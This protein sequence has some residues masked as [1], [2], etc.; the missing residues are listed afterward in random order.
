MESFLWDDNVFKLKKKTKKKTRGLLFLWC[1]RV[2]FVQPL[3][4][5]A[6]IKLLGKCRC[7]RFDSSLRLGCIVWCTLSLQKLPLCPLDPA[8]TSS[9][10]RVTPL[11]YSLVQWNWFSMVTGCTWVTCIQW[12][13]RANFTG[14]L[15]LKMQKIH[16]VNLIRLTSEITRNNL[17][18]LNLS[19][20]KPVRSLQKKNVGT[21]LRTTFARGSASR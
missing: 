3:S 19:P 10:S 13:Q 4:G 11:V 15:R 17:T 20:S 5:L 16:R 2:P 7:V 21:P 6:K 12:R 9:F 14:R 18:A 8:R 1:D